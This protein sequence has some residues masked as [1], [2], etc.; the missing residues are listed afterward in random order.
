M[1]GGMDG[2]SPDVLLNEFPFRELTLGEA[3]HNTLG[4]WFIFSVCL[5]SVFHWNASAQSQ[6]QSSTDFA[7]FAIKLREDGLLNFEPKLGG[8][9]GPAMA[10]RSLALDSGIE[11]RPWKIGIV[12]TV[13]WIGERPTA[14]NPVPNDRSSWD[15]NWLSNYGGYDDPNSKSRKDFIPMSFLPRQNP[16]YAALPYND[17]EGGH[18]KPEAKDLIPWFK[19]AFVRD[20]QSVLKGHW[21]AIRRRNRV[22]YAQWEDCGPFCTDHWQYV[23][24]DERPKANLNR[25]AGLDVSPAVRDYLGLG[26]TDVCDWTFVEFRKVPPGPWAMYGDNNS[27]VILRRQSNERFGHRNVQLTIPAH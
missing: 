13:F 8:T 22:C 23:F 25:N 5:F 11:R 7:K 16:F 10:G 17:V 18:T 26:D 12:T 6:Y 20:G 9:V 24:G 21:L 27:F 2:G 14:N 15:P 1:P 4:L 3:R 19:D